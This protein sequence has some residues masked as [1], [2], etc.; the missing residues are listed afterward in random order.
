MFDYH[1]EVLL[2]A[3]G[4]GLFASGV[5]YLWLERRQ[6]EPAVFSES[7]AAGGEVVS[8]SPRQKGINVRVFAQMDEAVYR[9]AFGED[10]SGQQALDEPHAQIYREVCAEIPDVIYQ[11]EYF[12]RKPLILP[13]LLAAIRHEENSLKALVDIIIQDPVLTVGVLKQANSAYYRVSEKPI[14]SLGKSVTLLGADGLRSLVASSLL[15]PVFMVDKG[16]FDNFSATYWLMAQNTALVAQTYAR[17]SRTSD[18][19]TAHLL[20]LT[21]YLSYIVI[22]RLSI[23]RYK[24]AELTPHSETLIALIDSHAAPLSEAI[25]DA[26]ALPVEIRR[27]LGGASPAGADASPLGVALYVGRVCAMAVLTDQDRKSQEQLVAQLL[28]SRGIPNAVIKT[29]WRKVHTLYE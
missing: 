17:A 28:K 20:G 10:C 2:I 29:V 4:A 12:P 13:Q 1:V 15:Q 24:E 19:F 22:F 9:R 7:S 14:E 25:A 3:A 6:V 21:Y 26:W 23:A 5:V 16:C 27:A 8:A 11:P 18:S